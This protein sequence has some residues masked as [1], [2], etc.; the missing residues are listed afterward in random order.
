MIT[1]Y[2]RIKNLF[3]LI[4]KC[5]I[6]FC[7][8]TISFSF[9]YS[10][11]ANE[12]TEDIDDFLADEREEHPCPE[13]FKTWELV[14]VIWMMVIGVLF[15]GF[16]L[17]TFFRKPKLRNFTNHFIVSLALADIL[18]IIFSPLILI[19]LL[20][21][22][23]DYGIG[24][25]AH[26]N[27]RIFC[28]LT[29]MLSFACIS[30]D[31]MLAITKPLYHRTLSRSCCIKVIIFIWIFSLVGT[32][33][34]FMLSEVIDPTIITCL[35]FSIAF[36][37]PTTV[38]ILSYAIIAKVVLSRRVE[39]LRAASNHDRNNQKKT[40]RVT[41]KILMVILPGAIMWGIYW[42]PFLNEFVSGGEED[43]YPHSLSTA[44]SMIPEL[45]AI[46]NPIIF[47]G[48]TS[49]FRKQLIIKSVCHVGT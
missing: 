10:F 36:A 27:C 19:L 13:N 33:L 32:F 21:E 18:T 43:I 46:V 2:T 34:D 35:N 48:M 5:V 42:F 17:V 44:V 30:V 15:N 26:F 40:L 37:I 1:L 24:D 20:F 31:R 8:Y 22:K 45:T 38:T 25:F 9:R 16:I 28:S 6:D 12:S 3:S 29:S 4:L 39:D 23:I 41:L 49:G 14:M 7:L 47:I 11:Q